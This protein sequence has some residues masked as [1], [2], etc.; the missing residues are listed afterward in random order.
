M[1]TLIMDIIEE[2]VFSFEGKESNCKYECS[3][4]GYCTRLFDCTFDN[5]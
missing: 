1:Y 3:C 5:D 2:S 4:D